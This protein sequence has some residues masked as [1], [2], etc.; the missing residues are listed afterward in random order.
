MGN[1]LFVVLHSVAYEGE[2]QFLGV[3]AEKRDAFEFAKKFVSNSLRK[4]MLEDGRWVSGAEEV[5]VY[6]VEVGVSFEKK[7]NGWVRE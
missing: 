5:E 4:F 7:D 3:F 1:K 6:E 2:S